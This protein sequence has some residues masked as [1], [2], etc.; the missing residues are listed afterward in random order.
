MGKFSHFD[1]LVLEL[2]NLNNL[3]NL[4]DTFSCRDYSFSMHNNTKLIEPTHIDEGWTTIHLPNG[5]VLKAK[6]VVMG[7]HQIL[8]ENNKPKLMD[9][10]NP[11]YAVNFSNAIIGIIPAGTTNI[12]GMN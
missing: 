5:D 12:K 8:D 1:Y 7:V 6:F 3:V 11:I 2:P 4:L 9:D 10:G